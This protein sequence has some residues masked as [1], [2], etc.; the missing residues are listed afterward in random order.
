ML[1]HNYNCALDNLSNS[2]TI[3]LEDLAQY[4]GCGVIHKEHFYSGYEFA[5][6]QAGFLYRKFVNET[7]ETSDYFDYALGCNVIDSVDYKNDWKSYFRNIP[8]EAAE[9]NAASPQQASCELLHIL[10]RGDIFQAREHRLLFSL[11]RIE[12]STFP[13]KFGLGFLA[14]F[15]S[16][17]GDF[18]KVRLLSGGKA[19]VVG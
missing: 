15:I 19:E 16:S 13:D 11:Q 17:D 5:A 3:W 7:I 9:D 8:Y 10:N 4:Q 18:F 2:H 12:Y 6:I 14:K 1:S